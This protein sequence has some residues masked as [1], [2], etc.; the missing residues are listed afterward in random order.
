MSDREGEKDLIGKISKKI[1]VEN[2]EGT[3]GGGLEG[4]ELANLGVANA[5]GRGRT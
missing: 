5:T 2:K 4:S 1:P 3:G